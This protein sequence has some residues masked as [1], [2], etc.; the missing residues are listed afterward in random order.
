MS[1]QKCSKECRQNREMDENNFEAVLS[2]ED[3][4]VDALLGYFELL[5]EE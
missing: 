2:R 1:R 4:D 3:V 5:E